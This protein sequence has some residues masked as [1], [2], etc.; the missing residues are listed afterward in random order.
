MIE[1]YVQEVWLHWFIS[2]RSLHLHYLASCCCLP[3]QV[4]LLASAVV[5]GPVKA[6]SYFTSQFGVSCYCS[7]CTEIICWS[8][9]GLVHNCGN[10]CWYQRRMIWIGLMVTPYRSWWL[11]EQVTLF[12][13]H[14]FHMFLYIVMYD[15]LCPALAGLTSS[16]F[17]HIWPNLAPAKF[18]S[19][20]GQFRLDLS[21]DAVSLHVSYW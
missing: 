17:W 13:S 7:L 12:D 11:T 3:L 1:I 14:T 2:I 19:N 18:W 9:G 21:A 5:K 4:I 15:I 10:V 16:H 8:L 6:Y 20:F